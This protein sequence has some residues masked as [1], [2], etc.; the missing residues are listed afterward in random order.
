MQG[1]RKFGTFAKGEEDLRYYH[2]V[3]LYETGEYVA[4]QKELACALP[5]IQVTDDV[6]RYR[7][8]IES[9]IA[10]TARK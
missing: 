3:A 6:S 9:T 5:F 2:A 7:V 4:A 1:F 8:K 10:R